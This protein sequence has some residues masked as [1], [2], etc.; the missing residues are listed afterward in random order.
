VRAPDFYPDKKLNEKIT[1]KLIKISLL[2]KL[3]TL[4]LPLI[5]R[6]L[7]GLCGLSNY[8]L[9]VDVPVPE[10]AISSPHCR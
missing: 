5:L 3:Y 2:D 6:V 8:V 7:C 10:T 4:L 1:K 9:G